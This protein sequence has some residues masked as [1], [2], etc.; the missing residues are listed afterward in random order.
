MK[1]KLRVSAYTVFK[2]RLVICSETIKKITFFCHSDFS[3]S[4]SSPALCLSL[5]LAHDVSSWGWGG[6]LLVQQR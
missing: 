4:L 6:G 2:H 5:S 1:L 3:H